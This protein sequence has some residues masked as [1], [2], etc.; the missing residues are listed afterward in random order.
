[1]SP[2]YCFNQPV[3]ELRFGENAAVWVACQYSFDG[4]ESF[5]TGLLAIRQADRGCGV[6]IKS[7]FEVMEAVVKNDESTMLN[8]L[9]LITDGRYQFVDFLTLCIGI[10]MVERCIVRI[11][12]G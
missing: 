8:G 6:Q 12:Q 10:F 2:R 3:T 1:L 9:Q 11:K 5:D 4:I 7:I